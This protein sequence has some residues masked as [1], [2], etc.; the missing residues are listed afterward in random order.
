MTA[1]A[2]CGIALI[3]A[4][5]GSAAAQAPTSGPL[6]RAWQA[7]RGYEGVI[8]ARDANGNYI[9]L[10]ETPQAFANSLSQYIADDFVA[11]IGLGQATAAFGGYLPT[12]YG[13]L[14][15]AQ[16][17]AGFQTVGVAADEG[18]RGDGTCDAVHTF[19]SGAVSGNVAY[20]VLNFAWMGSV[21]DAEGNRL[22]ITIPYSL[23]P[24]GG[25]GSVTFVG[26]CICTCV[27]VDG[28]WKIESFYFVLTPEALLNTAS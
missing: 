16:A 10:Q 28:Q 6:G 20:F 17:L 21:L 9:S 19:V 13:P 26:R 18:A 11:V 14:A 27:R 22:P 3:S 8:N 12:V 1:I 2:V 23:L 24:G 4:G 5:V 7:V 15:E 25:T